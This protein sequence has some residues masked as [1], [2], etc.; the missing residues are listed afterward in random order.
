MKIVLSYFDALQNRPS[1]KFFL[2]LF[3]LTNSPYFYITQLNYIHIFTNLKKLLKVKF[4]KT[5][6][7]VYD[8]FI[9]YFI[10][11]NSVLQIYVLIFA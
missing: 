7:N 11:L 8:K 2:N 6:Y 4:F 10:I 5:N 1:Y 3:F 9:F